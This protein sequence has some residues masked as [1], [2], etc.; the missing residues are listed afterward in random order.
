MGYCFPACPPSTGH[1]AW[2]ALQRPTGS[3]DSLL[4]AVVFAGEA[5]R[6]FG[7]PATKR[8]KA[9]L[10][11]PM[12]FPD[13]DRFTP[14]RKGVSSSFRGGDVRVSPSIA[15]LSGSLRTFFLAGPAGQFPRSVK[16]V[17]VKRVKS[18]NRPQNRWNRADVAVKEDAD[19]FSGE[20][21]VRGLKGLLDAIGDGVC[22]AG[23]ERGKRRHRSF[24]TKASS[25]SPRA[26]LRTGAFSGTGG[27]Y[28]D[29]NAPLKGALRN[30]ATKLSA[31]PRTAT[32]DVT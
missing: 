30:L 26:A 31:L 17:R 24:V 28:R 25:G 8:T 19:S 14:V 27:K 3:Q 13:M 6:R 18:P 5:K 10:E 32:T 12:L 29:P 15:R 23:A 20:A 16:V 4:R 1:S 21:V 22:G 2:R 11:L 9:R 7:S